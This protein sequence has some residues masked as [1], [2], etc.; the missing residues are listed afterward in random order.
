MIAQLRFLVKLGAELKLDAERT[1]PCGLRLSPRR[2]L[3]SLSAG[4]YSRA[5]WL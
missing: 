5:V 2:G 3:R 1:K 4:I